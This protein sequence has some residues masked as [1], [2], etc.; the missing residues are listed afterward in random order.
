MPNSFYLTPEDSYVLSLN[1][2]THEQAAEYLKNESRPEYRRAMKYWWHT[3]FYG[4]PK[5][6]LNDL[7]K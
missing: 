1:V 6:K 5:Q 7:L 2:T 4:L 3:I